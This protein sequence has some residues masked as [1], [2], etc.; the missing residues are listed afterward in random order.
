MTLFRPSS[1]LWLP[2]IAFLQPAAATIHYCT[3]TTSLHAALLSVLPGDE[4]VLAPGTYYDE[5]GVSGTAAHFPASVD[6][7]PGEGGRIVLRGEDPSNPPLLSGSDAGSRTVLR[8]F[9][10]HWTVRDLAVTNG[11]KGIIFDNADYGRIVNCHVYGIGYEA[12]HIRDGSDHCVVEGCNVHDTGIRNKGFGEAIYIGTDRGSWGRYDPYVWNTTVRNCTL[13][14]RVSAEAFDIKEGT[15]ETLIEFNTVDAT[16]ISDANYADSFID[17][18]A[19]RA[20]VRY[21]TF[22]RNDAPKLEKGI[23]VI[24]R[25]T[26]YSAYEHVIHDNYFYLDGVANIKLVDSYSG[27]RDVY[28]FN[29][30]RE[31]ASASDD[32]YARIV[33]NECCPP[34]Y[35]PPSDG[36]GVCTAPYGLASTEVSNTS[37]VLG[38]SGA[39]SNTTTYLVQYRE[40]GDVY[41]TEVN[42]TDGSKRLDLLDLA[43]STVY[44]WKVSSVCGDRF[45]ASA[46]GSAFLTLKDGDEEPPPPPGAIEIYNDGLI[47]FWSDY[48]WG[49]IYDFDSTEDSKVGAK[50]I[51][52]AFGG[53]G[54]VNLKHSR[55]GVDSSNITDVRF[56]VKGDAVANGPGDPTLQL[57]VNAQ[58]YDFEISNGVWNIYNIPLSEFGSP[59]TIEALVLQNREG[60][61]LLVHIDQIELLEPEETDSPTLHPSRVPT[62]QAPSSSRP[63]SYHPVTGDPTRLPSPPPTDGPSKE[64]TAGPTFELTSSPTD[65]PSEEDCVLVCKTMPPATPPSTLAPATPAPVE[66]PSSTFVIYGD[67][68]ASGWEDFGF[69]GT[70][71]FANDLRVSE[72]AHSLRA[73][74]NGWGGVNLKT[75]TPGFPL[76]DLGAGSNAANV[77]LR[78]WINGPGSLNLRVRV[79]EKMYSTTVAPQGQ[80][81]QASFPLDQFYSPVEVWQVGIQNAASGGVVLYLDR[82]ELHRSLFG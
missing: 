11:Q 31:P 69:K 9:G 5:D 35:D 45:S 54:G 14:P 34:W 48:S 28:A 67:T 50:S 61:D 33:I 70:F 38:W 24:Y 74:L 29:N 46:S 55:G 62:T 47:G 64:P 75:E 3:N 23:A 44:S 37:A 22:I 19:A 4:I 16:G 72:G 60:G 59:S 36:N 15:Q 65:Q 52:A 41:A 30:V 53:Y 13:G 79:N 68:L 12:I 81:V 21:N 2:A 25:G 8:V 40:F 76:A 78:F 63:P 42:V 1:I 51:K 7:T 10:D 77:Y 49:G 27:S 82:I 43:P 17:L 57:R 66:T 6:G 18:K 58:E 32:D 26:D 80:W 56:W 20:I 73:D 71:D 39:G